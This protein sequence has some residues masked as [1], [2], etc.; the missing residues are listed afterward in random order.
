MGD[1]AAAFKAFPKISLAVLMWQADEEFTGSANF[2]FDMSA[3][4]R[5]M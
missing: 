4:S 2:L 3:K 5:F 1:S